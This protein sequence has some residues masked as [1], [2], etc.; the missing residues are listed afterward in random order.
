MRHTCCAIVDH[1][2]D[3]YLGRL[4]VRTRLVAAAWDWSPNVRANL[5]LALMVSTG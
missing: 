2:D 4:S 1:D 5:K 3:H